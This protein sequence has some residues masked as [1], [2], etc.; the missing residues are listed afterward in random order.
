MSMDCARSSGKNIRH[1]RVS[2]RIASRI[3]APISML[4]ASR[5]PLATSPYSTTTGLTPTIGPPPRDPEVGNRVDVPPHAEGQT[6]HHESLSRQDCVPG[7]VGGGV[8]DGDAHRLRFQA[9]PHPTQ[10]AATVG[11]GGGATPQRSHLL[12]S[13][14][15]CGR[16]SDF[17][18]A[19]HRATVDASGTPTPPPL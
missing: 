2:R 18:C 10:P 5:R 8:L 14:A 12:S 9:P 13:S 11:R 3:C 16:R 4:S 6:L 7:R 17:T 19:K 1:S 15:A